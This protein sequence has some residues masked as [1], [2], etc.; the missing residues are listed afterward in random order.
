MEE[1]QQGIDSL[2]AK[3]REAQQKLAQA[4]M[5]LQVWGVGVGL[6]C[7]EE[8]Q[9]GIDSLRDKRQKA[10]QKLSPTAVLMRMRAG[11]CACVGA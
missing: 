9:Q 1:A 3:R 6:P 5:E 10:Q 11:S 4:N 2:R 7:S 8:A